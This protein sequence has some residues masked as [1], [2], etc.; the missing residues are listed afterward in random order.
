MLILL[1]GGVLALRQAILGVADREL[2]VLHAD[3][4]ERPD[5]LGTPSNTFWIAS[6]PRRLQASVV[7]A[8]A[9]CA[10]DVALLLHGRGETI[11][12][13]AATQAFLARRCVSSTVF[14]NSG[15]GAS[16]PPAHIATLNADTLAAYAALAARFA[17]PVRR[18]ILGHSMGVAPMLAAYP[19]LAPA[20]DRAI[21]A[22]G[23]SS[24]RG[25]GAPATMAAL[26]HESW[27]NVT[28]IAAACGPLPVLH[29]DADRTIPAAMARALDDAAP[30]QAL[31]V[32]LHC[33]VHD[34]MHRFPALAW[35]SPAL[36]FL[37]PPRIRNGEPSAAAERH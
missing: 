2:F 7:R 25:S 14:D 24:V 11:C 19:R 10:G 17:G 5:D 30:R 18:C 3:G 28:A 9:P 35:W 23:F 32:T 20:P 22:N 12:R 26:A 4:R 37:R 27:S 15:R 29:S 21:V 36:G 6:G 13:W 33:L 1:A 31:R 8:A 34:A 16:S